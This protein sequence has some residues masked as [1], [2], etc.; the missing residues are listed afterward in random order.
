LTSGLPGASARDNPSVTQ[1]Y[2]IWGVP[3]VSLFKDGA[4][5]ERLMGVASKEEIARKIDKHL[6]RALN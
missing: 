5:T 4:E 2:A 1:R 3:T 6:N